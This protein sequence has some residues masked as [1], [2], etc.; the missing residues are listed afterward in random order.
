MARLRIDDRA[1]LWQLADRAAALAAEMDSRDV[2]GVLHA[3]G[4][5]R[6]QKYPR[7]GPQPTAGSPGS[8]KPPP[9]PL[10]HRLFELLPEASEQEC[11]T[12]ILSMH[13]LG[14]NI[15]KDYQEITKRFM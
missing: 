7:V 8:P 5:L 2:A 9:E 6:L 10:I 15:P 12:A 4:S 14:W 3:L 13:L 1:A 11:A